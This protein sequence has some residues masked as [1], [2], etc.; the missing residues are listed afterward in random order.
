MP[1]P[2][3]CDG[4]QTMLP[5][6]RASLVAVLSRWWLPC[7][8]LGAG[9]K[10]FGWLSGTAVRLAQ[11]ANISHDP[12]CDWHGRDSRSQDGERLSAVA[13]HAARLGLQRFCTC[14][15][16][17]RVP[18]SLNKFRTDES[19]APNDCEPVLWYWQ[20]TG[21]DWDRQGHSYELEKKRHRR[22]VQ[23][24]SARQQEAE[25]DRQRE[26]YQ[27]KRPADDHIRRREQLA[28]QKQRKLEQAAVDAWTAQQPWRTRQQ[29][30]ARLLEDAKLDTAELLLPC[31]PSRCGRDD[32][33]RPCIHVLIGDDCLEMEEAEWVQDLAVCC[34]RYIE[35]LDDHVL[36]DLEGETCK[37]PKVL[38]LSETP[39][40]YLVPASAEE[41]RAAYAYAIAPGTRRRAGEFLTYA[42]ADALIDACNRWLDENAPDM[43]YDVMLDKQEARAKAKERKEA[44]REERFRA[45]QA[46]EEAKM[47]AEAQAR[48]VEL[49]VIRWD[50]DSVRWDGGK[51][52][53][54][55][56]AG[57][58]PPGCSSCRSSGAVMCATG[59]R[60]A[61]KRAVENKRE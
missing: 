14:G 36:Y 2:T 58:C 20:M 60:L 8:A 53:Y 46:A 38:Q 35:W 54:V 42:E 9:T 40:P 23:P 27:R 25:R 59:R 26:R 12:L 50:P 43:S 6:V 3:R 1:M 5:R 33:C 57:K 15:A 17:A 10:W 29:L 13:P 4:A 45:E 28:E 44:E 52:E 39:R 56:V 48:G 49:P 55:V 7:S 47:A 24:L 37:E 19:R 34:T 22:L 32:P 21:E 16:N 30:L 61:L 31:A 18:P 41:C 51:G 11:M